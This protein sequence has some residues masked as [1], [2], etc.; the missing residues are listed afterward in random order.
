ME[1]NN[2]TQTQLGIIGKRIGHKVSHRI[3]PVFYP[4]VNSVA[5]PF[6]EIF[7]CLN[8][9]KIE[10]LI[11]YFLRDEFSLSQEQVEIWRLHVNACAKCS[12]NLQFAL[13]PEDEIVYDDIIH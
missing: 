6:G 5:Q 7:S 11:H 2:N 13:K 1:I 10:K 8:K 12:Q 4:D 9:K 3:N